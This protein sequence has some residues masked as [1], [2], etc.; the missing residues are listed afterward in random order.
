[1]N[2]ERPMLDDDLITD[3]AQTP[4]YP[5]S[6]WEGIAIAVGAALLI[7]FG[8]GGL[9][10]KASIAFAPQR[11]ATIARSIIDYRIPGGSKGVFGVNIGGAKMASVTSLSPPEGLAI[12][13]PAAVELFV[14][15][16]PVGEKNDV[17]DTEEDPN[18][19]IVF[20]GFSFSY[21]PN[22]ELQVTAS[23]TDNRRFCGTVVPVNIQE[24]TLTLAQRPVPAIRYE[25]KTI[26]GRE[27][28]VA[29]LSTIGPDA[30]KNAD[31]VFASLE[32]QPGK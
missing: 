27:S 26:I 10:L 4:Q 11:A 19:D 15:R 14:A 12:H 1:M 13:K 32:C 24:G 28:Y 23:H 25:A 8:I 30:Q 21:Q 22:D 31:T 3:T 7:V 17:V 16:I 6:I 18:I 9:W 2:S 29:I 20:S 5:V